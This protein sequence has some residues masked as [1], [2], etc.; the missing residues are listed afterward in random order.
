MCDKYLSSA[1]KQADN[2]FLVFFFL[3]IFPVCHGSW[4]ESEHRAAFPLR[5]CLFVPSFLF[6]SV[7][8]SSS[9]SP[10]PLPPTLPSSPSSPSVTWLNLFIPQPRLVSGGLAGRAEMSR[11][12]EGGWKVN[13]RSEEDEC[14]QSFVCIFNDFPP[15]CRPDACATSS[16][17]RSHKLK[18]AHLLRFPSRQPSPF[19]RVINNNYSSGVCQMPFALCVRVCARSRRKRTLEAV[20]HR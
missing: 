4:D 13:N 8:A 15:P 3:F 6:V 14:G 12:C 2:K 17:L 5:L 16:A 9:S 18:I 7:L 1:N 20:A 10:P 11:G 19:H